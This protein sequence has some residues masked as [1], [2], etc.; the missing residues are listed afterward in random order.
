MS[1]K[2]QIYIFHILGMIEIWRFPQNCHAVFFLVTKNGVS[3]ILYD[4]ENM[5]EYNL[6][7]LCEKN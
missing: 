3:K 2:K 5:N 4:V 6:S 1:V 7:I